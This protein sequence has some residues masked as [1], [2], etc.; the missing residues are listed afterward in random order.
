MSAPRRMHPA[1]LELLA[2]LVSDRLAR[3]LERTAVPARPEWL[4]AADVAARFGIGRDWIYAHASEL[5]AVPLGETGEGRRP[6]LRFDAETVAERLRARS[7]GKGSPTPNVRSR[8]A[9]PDRARQ[10]TPSGRPLLPLRPRRRRVPPGN[11]S[12]PGGAPTPRG[13]ATEVD[14]PPR[15]RGYPCPGRRARPVATASAAS[16]RGGP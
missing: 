9:S 2:E 16:S 11:A 6:R 15:P 10:V 1:D 3:R 4:T 14:A 8:P 5:G 13:L 7:Q 12:G